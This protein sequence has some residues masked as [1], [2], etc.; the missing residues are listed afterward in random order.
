MNLIN[1][2]LNSGH[3]NP[4]TW[5][6]IF[7]KVEH[8][9]KIS[10]YGRI[11]TFHLTNLIR[12]FY[13]WGINGSERYG[14]IDVTADL[15]KELNFWKAIK[16]PPPTIL[17]PNSIFSKFYPARQLAVAGEFQWIR[18]KLVVLTLMMCEARVSA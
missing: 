1:E 18:G 12:K 16:I 7:G 14:S 6:R 4:H 2:T 15:S 11:Y 5:S 10:L 17:I 9:S 8:I 3:A 13:D